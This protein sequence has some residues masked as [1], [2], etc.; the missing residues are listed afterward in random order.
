[1][2][3]KRLKCIASLFS[4]EF[5]ASRVKVRD[6]MLPLAKVVALSPS[7]SSRQ[8]LKFGTASGL[9]R[10]PALTRAAH[11]ARTPGVMDNYTRD[12]HYTSRLSNPC[13]SLRKTHMPVP[14]FP[15]LVALPKKCKPKRRSSGPF[16]SWKVRK[17]KI[18][19]VLVNAV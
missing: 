9:D 17:P 11:L 5:C 8:V 14:I 1:M 15:A 13:Q 3:I 7:A 10:L 19:F 12:H 6:V 16:R 2:F 4:S 18:Q